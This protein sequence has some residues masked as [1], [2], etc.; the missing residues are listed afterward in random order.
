MPLRR[1]MLRRMQIFP[2]KP[3]I[4][5]TRA[6]AA[7]LLLARS[8]GHATESA[9]RAALDHTRPDLKLGPGDPPDPG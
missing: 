4:E 5:E 1:G 2:N 3:N 7:I 6:V 9:V 8:L